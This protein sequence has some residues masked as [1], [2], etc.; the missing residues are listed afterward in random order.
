MKTK[1]GQEYKVSLQT[2]TQVCHLRKKRQK[3][4]G[5]SRK[6]CVAALRRPGAAVQRFPI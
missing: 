1:V 3:E 5:L 4:G 2:V 6:S